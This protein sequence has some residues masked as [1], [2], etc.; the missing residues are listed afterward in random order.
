M[1]QWSPFTAA[2]VA[3][4]A[5][6]CLGAGACGKNSV[7]PPLAEGFRLD[8]PGKAART[9]LSVEDISYTNSDFARFARLTLGDNA[10][11]LTAEAAGRLFDDYIERKLIVG[12][13]SVGNFGLTDEERTKSLEVFKSNQAG[14]GPESASAS[15]SPE[16][17]LEGILVDKYLAEQVKEI[18]V[19]EE[20][21]AAYYEAHKNEFLQPERLQVSQILLSAE[22]KAG[23]VLE[24]LRTAGEKEFRDAARTESEGPEAEKGGLMGVFSLGQLPLELEKVIFALGEGKISRV[25]QSPYGYHIFRLDKKLESR[26]IPAA[27]AAP[28]IRAKLLEQKNQAAIDA[29]VASLKTT[30]KWSV[31]VKNL[32]FIY[33]SPE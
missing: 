10:E 22:G 8:D 26:L 31:I 15:A 24:R 5:V 9:V 19:G 1:K 23:Q 32:P 20:E 16:D 2:A 28:I 27:E 21:I 14:A 11:G 12:A 29:H 33:Q 13:A 4:A 25:V 3:T 17:F 18:T 7:S 30:M 6:L